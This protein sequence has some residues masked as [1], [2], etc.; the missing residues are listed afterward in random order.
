G[1]DR[2]RGIGSN[3]IEVWQVWVQEAKIRVS[4][5]IL[6]LEERS[7]KANLEGYIGEVHE[8]RPHVQSYFWVEVV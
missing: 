8:P 2:E 3:G 5:G 4:E 6:N 7:S 1:Q